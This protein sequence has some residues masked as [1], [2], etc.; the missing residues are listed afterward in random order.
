MV[1]LD[2]GYDSLFLLAVLLKEASERID[3]GGLTRHPSLG[4]CIRRIQVV[5]DPLNMARYHDLSLAAFH[6]VED[7]A[8]AKRM[9]EAYDGYFGSYLATMESILPTALPHL[10][11]LNWRDQIPMPPSMFTALACSSIRHLKLWQITSDGAFDIHLP[12]S[13]PRGDWP[14]RSLEL[15]PHW[16]IGRQGRLRPFRLC[17]SILRLCAATLESLTWRVMSRNFH[18]EEIQR[19]DFSG[20]KPPGFPCLRKIHLGAMPVSSSLL[21]RLLCSESYCR[22]EVLAIEKGTDTVRSD[23]FNRCGKIPSLET[24]VWSSLSHRGDDL[25]SFLSSNSQL[26]KLSLYHQQTPSFLGVRVLPLLSGSFRRLV[27]L[28]LK[29]SGDCIP[30]SALEQI[31]TLQSLRQLSLSADDTSNMGNPWV[32]D[33]HIMRSYLG[34]LQSLRKIAFDRDCYD[35]KS[36]STVPTSDTDE[37]KTAEDV[38]ASNEVD[39]DLSDSARSG[40]WERRHLR[41]VLLE[42]DRYCRLL[43]EL[44]WMY[45]GQLPIAIVES[46]DPEK[47]REAVALPFERVQCDLML[48]RMFGHENVAPETW[49]LY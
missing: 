8:P 45:L 47:G 36:E 3:N 44:Q 17:A 43:L 4:A 11:V 28:W 42:A 16:R 25:I 21:G 12:D 22:L 7:G 5:V 15:M 23:F 6:K 31:A 41:R 39:S 48:R 30:E 13:L 10:E 33:H 19:L 26:S 20:L 37:E 9:K 29:W 49:E 38:E 35:G 27:S 2:Y 1:K 24:L 46:A 34:K 18:E 40:P 14:L 32:I